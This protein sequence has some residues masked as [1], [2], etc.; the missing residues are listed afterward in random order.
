ML[1]LRAGI[2][3]LGTLVSRA[4]GLVREMVLAAFFDRVYTDAFFVAYAI[5]NTLRLLFA[6]GGVASA[7]LPVL[8]QVR[9]D[10]GDDEA[11]R[12]FQAVRGLSLLSLIAVSIVGVA[13][14]RP[15]CELFASGFHDVPGQFERTVTLTR[16]VFPYILFMGSAALG[17]AAL[18]THRRFAVAAFSPALL[19]VAIIACALT[20]PGVL[21]LRGYDVS[22]AL[23][24]GALFG[25]VLQVVAQWPALWNIGYLRRPTFDFAH[26][27]V[28]EVARR[29]LPVAVGLG[30]YSLDIVLCRRFLSELGV[31]AQSYFTW[32]MRLCDFPQGIFI[33]ALSTA[34]LPSLSSLAAAREPHE[35]GKTYAYG[36][37]LAMFVA[38]PAT[39]LLVVLAH[40]LVVAIFERGAFGPDASVETARSLV[41]Q[42]LGIWAVAGVRQLVTVYYA[43]GDTRTPVVVS[44]LDLLVFVAIAI[45]L[46]G[47]LGHVGIGV[48][49]TGASVV[50]L[51][52]LWGM[53]RR[54][55]PNTRIT[56]IAGSMLRTLIASLVAGGAAWWVAGQATGLV[57][58]RTRWLPAAAGILVFGA[59]FVLGAWA[60]RSPEMVALASSLQRK[61]AARRLGA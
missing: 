10:R 4:T 11:R 21:A 45:A 40:P 34:S 43:L 51:V 5:P 36:M 16:W 26:P 60:L 52:L 32:A 33:V 48:A 49:L 59:F 37:R 31:G 54:K 7:V 44:A 8:S 3:G 56:E 1:A 2:V 24:F 39:V 17:L 22:L 13:F 18:N 6:E 53:L 28:R 55:V 23:A 41:A 58:E 14:A 12:F 50:Q 47:P 25:G 15:L 38:I 35:V 42:G 61:L 30:V 29:L 46:R 27:A 19:N 57:G 20:L 9:H